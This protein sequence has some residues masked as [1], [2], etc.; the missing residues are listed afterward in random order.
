MNDSTR[1]VRC[2]IFCRVI[3]NFGDVGVTWRLSRLLAHEFGW[4]VR[5]FVDDVSALKALLSQEDVDK[6]KA[7]RSSPAILPWNCPPNNEFQ[8]GVDATFRVVVEAFACELPEA[9]IRAMADA[10]RAGQAVIW[11]NLEYLSAE[12]W[13]DDHHLLASPQSN[14]LTKHFFFP[15]FTEKSGGLIRERGI[16]LARP[17]PDA[18]MV[19]PLNVFAFAYD[20]D[21]ATAA[22]EA[23]ANDA[24]IKLTMPET[25]LLARVFS[26][27]PGARIARRAFVPQVEF[28]RLL[29]EF[30][31]LVVRGEDSFLRAQYAAKPFVWHIYPQDEEAHLTKLDAFLN[32]YMVGLEPAAAN[33]LRELWMCWNGAS[34]KA[35]GDAWEA[36]LP[37]LVALQAHA[38]AWQHRLLRESDLATRLVTFCEKTIKI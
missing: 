20:T 38:M 11:L 27:S 21:S 25:P 13:I 36:F 8:Y 22:C 30:D 33:A 15:G 34:S 2:D 6:H 1:V 16:A 17:S 31:V 24:R 7:G 23:L 19:A 28:D 26:H 29:R 10:A 14:G 3:D 18:Q 5:L 4:D 32:R 9:V 12:A 37:H 35:F